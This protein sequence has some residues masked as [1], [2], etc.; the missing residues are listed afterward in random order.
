LLQNHASDLDYEL[1]FTGK[2][3]NGQKIGPAILHLYER[4]TPAEQVD[5]LNLLIE[6]NDAP[7]HINGKKYM[8]DGYTPVILYGARKVTV[9]E[10]FL[11]NYPESIDLYERKNIFQENCFMRD[12]L[13]YD[14]QVVNYLI[15][16]TNFLED[17][18]LQTTYDNGDTVFSKILGKVDDTNL[19]VVLQKIGPRKIS[20]KGWWDNVFLARMISNYF[21]NTDAALCRQPNGNTPLMT[22]VND[23]FQ[24]RVKYILE[25][26]AEHLDLDARCYFGFTFFMLICG[27][28]YT[29]LVRYVLENHPHKININDKNCNN[30]SA[31]DIAARAGHTEITALISNHLENQERSLRL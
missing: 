1:E 14:G 25:N 31:L 12:A 21:Y 20:Q 6:Y 7:E 3:V 27:K 17:F 29:D 9:L 16:E 23:G 30:E 24:T 28:G 13:H 10:F 26:Y 4:S 22:L 18:D 8:D 5:M 11:R 19:R 2:V 15:A